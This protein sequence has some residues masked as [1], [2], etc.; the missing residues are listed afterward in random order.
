MNGD[1]EG[2]K[3][4]KLTIDLSSSGTDTAEVAADFGAEIRKIWPTA[5]HA[6]MRGGAPSF[7]GNTWC[8]MADQKNG[9]NWK[10]L[11]L[12]TWN[13]KEGNC[14]ANWQTRPPHRNT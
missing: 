1:G 2:M 13:L 9:D 14:W 8:L 12:F 7:D 11:G 10:T 6:R 5:T 4:F 3:L